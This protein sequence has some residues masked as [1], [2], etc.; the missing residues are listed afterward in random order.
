M[1]KFYSWLRNYYLLFFSLFNIAIINAALATQNN[2]FDNTKL[3]VWTN[4]AIIAT[5]TY[6]YKNFLSR[7]KEIAKYFTAKGWTSYSTALNDAKIPAIIQQNAYFVSS[8]ATIPPQIKLINANQWQ[9]IMP[10]L[11]LYENP[12]S[13]QTQHLLVTINF[14]LAPPGQGVRGLAIESLQTKSIH[15]ACPCQKPTSAD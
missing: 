7:Q 11:V 14:I 3:A 5:Y 13:Q 10:I 12:Q 6:N 2:A 15:P 9:A 4:E 8:V 1:Y